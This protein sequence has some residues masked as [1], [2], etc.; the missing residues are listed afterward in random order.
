MTDHDGGTRPRVCIVGGGPAGVMAGVL[1]ARQ[2]VPVTVLEKHADF[3]RD[4]RGD[5][6][7]PSTLEILDELSWRDDFLRLPHD[8]MSSVEIAFGDERVLVADF[9][10]L[11]AASPFVAFVPQWDFLTFLAERGAALPDFALR[12]G[13][14]VTGLVRERGRVTGVT[15]MQ[16][17]Q[18][19]RFDADLVI[20]ADGR[21]SVVRTLA[22]LAVTADTTPIDVFWMRV[23]RR[24][25]E[26]LPLF[27]GGGGALICIDRGAYWQL[28]YAFP[29]GTADRLRRA[30]LDALRTRIAALRPEL[31][32]ATSALTGWDDV[33]ELKVRVDH[34]R[35]WSAPGLLCIG[36]AAHAMSPAGGVGINLAIQDAVAT[37]NLLGPILVE[38]LPSDRELDAVRR[39]RLVP[40]RVTQ[41]FQD[42]ILRGF[43]APADAAAPIRLPRP[44]R[45]VRR[46]AFLR[47][48]TG[49][50]IGLGVRP[51]HVRP[52]GVRP[53]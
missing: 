42:R 26:H 27:T 28:A 20:G 18:A 12:H 38:R 40:A 34:L 50:L 7:H 43:Y 36:D 10:R 49:R 51:E 5:T 37:A 35:R 21:S 31:A 6:I 22:G 11:R 25:G 8:A 53:R 4:F 45:I 47:H 13:V 2:G 16:D 33:H 41:R 9:S 30:G 29:P 19:V 23:P 1:L 24:Q 44:L 39:R 15:G 48:L 46:L 17:G 3:H 32:D 52:A 14:E